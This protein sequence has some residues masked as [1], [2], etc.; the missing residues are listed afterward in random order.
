MGIHHS[1]YPVILNNSQPWIKLISGPP[2]L[3]GILSCN[4]QSRSQAIT[5]HFMQTT[6]TMHL[7]GRVGIVKSMRHHLITEQLVHLFERLALGLRVEENNNHAMARLLQM[8]KM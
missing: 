5:L 2:F 1:A 7:F 3:L 8:K 4:C 6:V